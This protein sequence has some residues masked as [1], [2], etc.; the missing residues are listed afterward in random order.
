MYAKNSELFGGRRWAMEK[1]LSNW[2]G[3]K[4]AD[5]TRPKSPETTLSSEKRKRCD[6]PPGEPS[7][8]PF[9]CAVDLHQTFGAWRDPTGGG[10]SIRWQGR[11][12]P[13]KHRP[14]PRLT[15][16]LFALILRCCQR[17]KRLGMHLHLGLLG[18]LSMCH[19]QQRS[20]EQHTV[21]WWSLQ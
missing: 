2:L 15:A 8:S 9:P 7:F 3:G 5:S 20:H 11:R 14:T 17:R 12:H 1:F 13:G 18:I 6:Q 16:A 4:T 21:P 10:T 19:L